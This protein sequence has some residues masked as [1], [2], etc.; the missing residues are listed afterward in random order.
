MYHIF[1]IAFDKQKDITEVFCIISKAFDHVWH[2]DLLVKLKRIG[3]TN[4]LVEWFADNLN[5]RKQC[6]V[7]NGQ[8]STFQNS[9]GVCPR[10]SNV[11]S[12]TQLT[13]LKMPGQLK[14]DYSLTP[15]ALYSC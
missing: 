1:T 12:Y 9:S 5:G 14:L 8:F 3:I 7:I 10:S 6:V 2:S 15:D 11:F 13:L 4:N